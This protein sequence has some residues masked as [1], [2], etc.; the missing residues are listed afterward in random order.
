MWVLTKGGIVCVNMQS[1]A[2]DHTVCTCSM[3][4][5]QPVSRKYAAYCLGD[6]YVLTP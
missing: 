6:A 4:S 5:D 1:G 3:V 2:L